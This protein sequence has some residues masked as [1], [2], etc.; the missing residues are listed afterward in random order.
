MSVNE[1]SIS[2]TVKGI[3]NSDLYF[4][5]SLQR[6]YCNITALARLIKPQIDQILDR[7]INI[8]SI[9]TAVKRSK[10][11]YNAPK[12]PTA[13]VLASSKISVKT[14]VAK[15]SIDKSKKTIEKVAKALQNIDNFISVSES[16]LSITFVFDDAL[17]DKVKAMFSN[18]EILEIEEDLAA[19]MVHSP[20][21]IIKTPGCAIAFYNQLAYR[22]INIEDTVSCYTDTIVLVK[23]SDV[24]K[25]FNALTDLISNS[26]KLPKKRR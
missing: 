12:L 18:Y 25:A 9:V 20:E 22:H 11:I 13:S 4:Q 6:N 5:D 21:E 19:I 3:M 26:R 10:N 17:L 8:E 7:N 14:D 2:G 24:G 1:K 23:M 16:I 15:L